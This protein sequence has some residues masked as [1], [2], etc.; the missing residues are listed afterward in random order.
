MMTCGTPSPSTSYRR[1]HS[2]QSGVEVSILR[3]TYFAASGASASLVSSCRAI[4]TQY[5]QFVVPPMASNGRPVRLTSATALS[6]LYSTRTGSADHAL[7]AAVQLQARIT[8]HSRGQ[9]LASK[10]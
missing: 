1:V 10:R 4:R 5:G 8:P 3:M 7:G 2:C 6:V 9:R